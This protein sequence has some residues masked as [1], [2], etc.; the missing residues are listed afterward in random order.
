M[1]TLKR[2]LSQICP[3]DWFMS[4]DLKDAYFQIQV[5]PHHRRLMRF[6]F[7]GVAYQHKVLPFGLSL[8][9]RTFTLQQVCG[10]IHKSPGRPHLKATLHAGE[11]P[12]C[13]GSDQSALTED[14]TCAGQ[15]EPRSRHVEKQF[16][17]RG[18]DAPPTRGSE[19]LGSLWQSSSRPLRL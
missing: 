18:M 3:G 13:V 19:N 16:F 17:F 8:A 9:P 7:K 6:A 11:R 2:I 4:L 12:S 10:V 5:A 1:I 14:D 15:N